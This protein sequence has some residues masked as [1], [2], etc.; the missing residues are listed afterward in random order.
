MKLGVAYNIFDGTELLANSITSIRQSVDYICGIYQST[1]NFGNRIN[2]DLKTLLQDYKAQGLIDEF[3]EYSPLL[4]Q[5]PHQ[6]ECKKRNIGLEMCIHR[7]CTHYITMDVDEFYTRQEFDHAKCIISDG[8]YDSSACQMLTYYKTPEFVLDPPEEYYVPFIYRI[9]QRRFR[10]Y[11]KWPVLADPTRKLDA[12]KIKIFERKELQMHHLSY[13]RN[14]I[15]LK[16]ENSSAKKN[17][18]GRISK[19]T[20]H[21]NT[22]KEGDKALLAGQEERYYNLA[23][24][25][26]VFNR[27]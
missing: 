26:S 22:W 9:D 16:L 1:S 19:I 25:P 3:I 24:V 12:N 20:H 13:V 17:F 15:R 5:T 18:A 14:D 2:L 4:A 10:E 11:I 21:F 6:N 8:N 23:K 7:G 27:Q